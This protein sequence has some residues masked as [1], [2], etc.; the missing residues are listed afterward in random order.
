MADDTEEPR[1]QISDPRGTAYDA[2]E[3]VADT[4][5]AVPVRKARAK[6]SEELQV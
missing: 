5:A 2:K 4:G 6:I 3:D 1:G